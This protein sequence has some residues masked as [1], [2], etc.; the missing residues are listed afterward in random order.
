MAYLVICLFFGLAGGWVGR[1]K[2]SSFVLWF[3]ISA[4]I[5]FLGLLAAV[6][7]RYERDEVRRQ[8]PRCG[9]VVKLYDQVCMRCGEDMEFPDVAIVP[10]SAT[11]HR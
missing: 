4:L 9:S 11:T 6:F 8:C 2:G 5:P 10:E 3:L 7:Y 1:I